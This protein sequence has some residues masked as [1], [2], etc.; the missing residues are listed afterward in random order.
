MKLNYKKVIFVGF[1]FFLILAFWQAY[2][3]IVPLMLV[4]KFG[5]NQTVYGVIMALDNEI[6][7][8]QTHAVYRSRHHCRDLRVYRFILYG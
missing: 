4:N 8:R 5:L 2:D 1:A 6:K 3:A 7:I